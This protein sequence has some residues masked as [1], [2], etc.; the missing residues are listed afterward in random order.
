MRKSFEKQA[1]YVLPPDWNAASIADRSAIMAGGSMP[2]N[3]CTHLAPANCPVN[4]QSNSATS[5]T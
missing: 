1:A 2:S 3:G 4:D 5:A